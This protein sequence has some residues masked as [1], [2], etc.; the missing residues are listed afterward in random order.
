MHLCARNKYNLCKYYHL[1]QD[2]RYIL[3]LY[4]LFKR[5]AVFENVLSGKHKP[6]TR[7]HLS[8]IL[9]VFT[10]VDH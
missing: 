2:K 9:D 10:K 5:S 6:M 7:L 8:E 4:V 3:K 1:N